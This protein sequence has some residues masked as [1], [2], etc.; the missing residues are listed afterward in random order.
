M[1]DED[2]SVWRTTEE[3]SW[4]QVLSIPAGTA[5]RDI[6][7]ALDRLPGSKQIHTFC[8]GNVPPDYFPK[9]QLKGGS[10]E[11]KRMQQVWLRS[12]NTDQS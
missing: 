9:A 7:N 12:R 10:R 5:L 3:G 8:K 6:E 4:E 2:R 11:S 1:N